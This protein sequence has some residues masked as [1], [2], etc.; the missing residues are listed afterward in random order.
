MPFEF[1]KKKPKDEPEVASTKS[2]P[3]AS[4]RASTI[5]IKRGGKMATIDIIKLKRL[6]NGVDMDGET[7]SMKCSHF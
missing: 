3:S 7:V 2:R 4:S 1:F 6:L 5:T